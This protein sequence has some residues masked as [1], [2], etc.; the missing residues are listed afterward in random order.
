MFL[1][2]TLNLG[3]FWVDPGSPGERAE[4]MNKCALYTSFLL[5]LMFLALCLTSFPFWRILIK[6]PFLLNGSLDLL[7]FRKP[8]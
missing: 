6:H 4:A 5:S 7:I 1:N 8:C 2:R 3:I